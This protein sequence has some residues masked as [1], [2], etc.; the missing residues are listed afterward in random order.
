[1]A[2]IKLMAFDLD[3]TLSQHKTPLEP[4]HRET[5]YRLREKYA[6]VM[7]GA[8]QCTRVFNQ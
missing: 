7:V 3:G 6:L 8:G 4:L 5:L 1:M 2:T